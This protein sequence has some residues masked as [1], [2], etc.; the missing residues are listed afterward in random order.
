MSIGA[1]YLELFVN[2]TEMG[3]EKPNKIKKKF[4]KSETLFI[5]SIY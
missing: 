3:I 5:K 4:F 1:E 2:A